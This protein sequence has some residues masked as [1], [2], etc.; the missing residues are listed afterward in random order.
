[1]G[2]NI[3]SPYLEP[4]TIVLQAIEG[5]VESTQ[6]PPKVLICGPKKTGKSSLAR[7]VINALLAHHDSVNLLEADCGQPQFGPPG[8]VSMTNVSEP[9][10][11]P[12]H[13]VLRQPDETMVIGDVSAES[14]PITYIN[15][16]R[17]LLE[18]HYGTPPSGMVPFIAT[19]VIC[20]TYLRRRFLYITPNNHPRK[21]QLLGP[22]ETVK[23]LV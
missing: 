2:A 10:L 21:P 8:F 5:L 7:R 14:N 15:T 18:G 11:L 17:K 19:A 3:C 16:I 4:G 20:I 12:P 1:M 22:N 9:L 23:Y 13:C 6:N